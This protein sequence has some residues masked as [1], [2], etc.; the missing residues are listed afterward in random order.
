MNSA[1]IKISG[2]CPTVTYNIYTKFELNRMYHLDS[3][4]FIHIHMHAHIH[5]YIG[6]P[7]NNINKFMKPQ[8]I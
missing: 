2:I 5:T 7:K 6:H 1:F 4:L 8:N 3:I